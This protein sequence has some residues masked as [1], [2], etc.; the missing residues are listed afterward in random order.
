MN[1]GVIISLVCAYLL[2][3]LPTGVWLS[4]L[5]YGRDIRDY[6]NGNSGARNVTH[7]LGW[8]AGIIVAFGDFLKGALAM[9]V[10]RRMGLT[11]EWQILSGFS[12]VIG[13]DFP[14]FAEFKGGQGMAT[15]LG[16]MMVLFYRETL[17]GLLIFGLVYLLIRHFDI[18]A[19]VGLGGMA[20]LLWTNN[21]PRILLYYL[22]AAFL[23][24]PLKKLLDARFRIPEKAEQHIKN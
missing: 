22:V 10:A 6:G 1:S 18:S 20:F 16:T 12:A 2:G 24:I 21:E 5:L 13:H 23:S 9:L 17:I 15:S 3:S 8:K 4:R 19:T 14:V 11:L 7:V